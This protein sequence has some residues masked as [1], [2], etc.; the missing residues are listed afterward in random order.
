MPPADP[1]LLH[2]QSFH[3]RSAA[4]AVDLVEG[5]LVVRRYS[6]DAALLVVCV[7]ACTG[8][9]ARAELCAMLPLVRDVRLLVQLA[10]IPFCRIPVVQ[11]PGCHVIQA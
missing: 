4:D 6:Y 7:C 11:R 5:T 3:C 9:R 1:A 10:G 2:R 8:M